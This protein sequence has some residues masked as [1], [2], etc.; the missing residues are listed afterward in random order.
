VAKTVVIGKIQVNRRRFIDYFPIR[1]DQNR[2]ESGRVQ[3]KKIRAAMFVVK[4][5]NR[6]SS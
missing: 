4:D 2:N 3:G 1:F 6:R 5:I